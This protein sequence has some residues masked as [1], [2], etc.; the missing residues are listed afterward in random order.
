M[1]GKD[2]WFIQRQLWIA[3][4]QPKQHQD[5]GIVVRTVILGIILTA[6]LIVW[7]YGMGWGGE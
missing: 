1:I 4:M 7:H 3:S 2:L 5:I 6:C